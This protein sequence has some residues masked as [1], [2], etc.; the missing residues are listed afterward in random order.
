MNH[1]FS[2][3]KNSMKKTVFKDLSF[4]NERKNAVKE[5]ILAKQSNTNL[6]SWKEETL[7][8]LFELLQNEAKMGY[9]LSIQ[10]IQRND[11]TFQNNEGQL[12]SLL[13]LLENK[14]FLH[15][16]WIEGKKYYS[17]TKKGEKS[18]IA[19]NKQGISQQKVS[20]KHL[21]EEASL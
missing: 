8:L 10:L 2:N 13:H 16:T 9:D 18:L 20:L 12:Y 5:A 7:L 4:S 17:L 1:P 3:I 6:Q 14:G 11:L 19:S 15:S 21:I